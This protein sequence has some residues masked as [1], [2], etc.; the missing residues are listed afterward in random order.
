MANFKQFSP[1]ICIIKTSLLS[2]LYQITSI[3]WENNK[4]QALADILPM[5]E[6]NIS[7]R[8]TNRP[9]ARAR[10]EDMMYTLNTLDA[11]ILPWIAGAVFGHIKPLISY[12]DHLMLPIKPREYQL[13]QIFKIMAKVPLQ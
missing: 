3:C 6:A 7:L 11:T 2:I 8:A 1:Q 13:F 10:L 9:L 4:K 5:N 12:L